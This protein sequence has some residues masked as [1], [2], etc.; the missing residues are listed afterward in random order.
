MKIISNLNRGFDYNGKEIRGKTDF[1]ISAVIPPG[2]KN[3]DNIIKRMQKKIDA[4]ARFLQTQPMYDIEKTRS[5][6]SKAKDLNVPILLGVMPL[7]GLK[8][9]QYMNENVAGIDI[10]DEVIEK[11]KGGV[12]GVEITKEFVKEIYGYEGLSGIHI[13]VYHA[14]NIILKKI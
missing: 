1:F 13:I 7:K 2:A 4:G 11:L 9:A 5:F 14:R 12:K 10:P 3:L 6:L 8:M